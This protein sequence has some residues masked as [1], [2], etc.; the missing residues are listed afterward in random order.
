MGDI[1]DSHIQCLLFLLDDKVKTVDDIR[2][3]TALSVL[4]VIPVY[5]SVNAKDG[6][7][8]KRGEKA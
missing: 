6:K 2:K 4:A 5:Q 3:Y 8:P 7:K 1:T